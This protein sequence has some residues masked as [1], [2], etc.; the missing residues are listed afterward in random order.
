MVQLVQAVLYCLSRVISMARMAAMSLTTW[1]AGRSGGLDLSGG[2]RTH[3]IG[4]GRWQ[5][6]GCLGGKVGG[7]TAVRGLSAYNIGCRKAV[8]VL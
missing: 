3:A 5:P 2:I 8:I 7:I 1:A 6:P 4:K